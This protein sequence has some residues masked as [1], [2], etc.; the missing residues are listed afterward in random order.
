MKKIIFA[1]AAFLMAA[2]TGCQKEQTDP[3]QTISF[4]VEEAAT[5]TEFTNPS[6]TSYPVL[7]QSTDKV[8]VFPNSFSDGKTS[9]ITVSSDRKTADF[10]ASFNLTSVS[11]A[12]SFSLLSPASSFSSVGSGHVAS[13]TVPSTQ[14]PT[15]KSPDAAA[16]ILV[17]K[18]GP[19]RRVPS[20]VTFIPEHMTAYV[21]LTLTNTS[22]LGDLKGVTLTST[23]PLAGIAAYDFDEKTVTPSKNDASY[24][25]QAKVSSSSQTDIWFA[26]FPAQ[27][28]GTTLTIVATFST[29]NGSLKT[30][31]REITVPTGKNLEPGKIAVL[32][33][34]MNPSIP[35]TGVSLDK[36]SLSLNVGKTAT[37]TA[38]VTPSNATDKSVSW[39]SSNT[40]VATVSSSGVVTGVKAGSATI[41]V[42]TNDGGKTATCA[43]TVNATTVAVTGVSLDKTSLS[44]DVGKTATL[45][46]TVTPSNATDKSVSWKSSNTSVATVSSSGVVTGVKAGSATITVTTNDG[47]KTATCA[48]TVMNRATKV[49]I[50]S[51][52]GAFYDEGALHLTPSTS[53]TIS[54]SVTYADGS[55]VNNTGAQLV[56]TSGTGFSVSGRVVSCT[57]AAVTKS[58]VL[59]VQVTNADGTI[60]SDTITL[61]AWD[62][63]TSVKMVWKYNSYKPMSE[64]YCLEGH[65]YN[66][67]VEILPSTAYQKVRIYVWD[68]NN[69]LTDTWTIKELSENL[70]YYF[71]APSPTTNTVAAYQDL[72][73]YIQVQDFVTQKWNDHQECNLTNIDV[74][75]PKPFDLI[76]YQQSAGGKGDYRIIDG[77]L[78]ILCKTD[79][80]SNSACYS[81]KDFYCK[82]ISSYSAPTG[83]KFVGIVT[84]YFKGTEQDLPNALGL[85]SPSQ[86]KVYNANGKALDSGRIHGF[87][88]SLYN[89][90][91]DIWSAEN[92][93][94]PGD[95]N[96]SKELLEGSASSTIYYGSVYN[97]MNGFNLT[98]AAHQYNVWRGDSHAIRVA[99]RVWD[100][101]EPG[102]ELTC[103][104]FPKSNPKNT[105]I[106]R[107]WFVPTIWNWRHLCGSDEKFYDTAIIKKINAQITSLGFG[108]KVFPYSTDSYWTINTSS[109][110]MARIVY[111]DGFADRAKS[112]SAGIRP[113]LIF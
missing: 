19:F 86:L 21:K 33:V 45:T 66:F 43:V 93:D 20:T 37:L 38:T 83:Y 58:G 90:T 92:D 59:K 112:N 98:V 96:F 49:T 34:D 76:A 113:F 2:L 68:K 50:A 17:A 80:S 75:A 15:A 85:S 13:I 101:G 88:I 91:A 54:Y 100:Y 7:W 95:A 25:V 24:S 41:T 74:D 84:A 5:R 52:T 22:G 9:A 32:S 87:A 26:T 67:D 3:R 62:D 1:C 89:A 14:T 36:T 55:I 78:R 82:K 10:N 29:K 6:G 18:A 79:P 81:V 107:P 106:M 73:A 11:A 40:S 16:Q 42:T 39:K 4:S 108:N 70:S 51:K 102:Y 111:A 60:V 104:A 109:N 8:M 48:V 71:I 57:S 56:L 46:A 53:R 94:V 105:F 35:V 28:A 110:K 12:S 23:K 63:P 97:Q 103:R 99:D 64:G 27:V 65:Q 44:V 69:N 72:Y 47:G 77:G 31:T 61:K 30:K